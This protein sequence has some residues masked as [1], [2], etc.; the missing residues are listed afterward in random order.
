MAALK[1]LIRKE[2]IQ[3]WRNSF[4]PKLVFS[5]PVLVMLIVPLVANMEVKGV[6][7]AYVDNDASM[8][9]QRMLSH[10]S[11]SPHFK[12][13]TVTHDYAEAFRL[14]EDCK[15]DVILTIPDGFEP[16]MTSGNVKKIKID[17]NAV[18]ATKGMQGSQ[19]VVQ[20]IAMTLQEVMGEQGVTVSGSD[21][22][23]SIRYYYNETLDYRYYM[24]PAFMVILVLVICCFIPALNLVV[25][26]EKGT[27]EQI[28]VTPVR[29]IEFILS[30]LIPYWVIGIIVV[31]EAIVTVGLVYGL[32]PEGNIGALFLASLL[33]SLVLSGFAVAVANRSD[34]MQQC[35]FVMFF[36]VMVFMLMG[37]LL[38]PIS[39]MPEWA[40]EITTV[41]PTRYFI[42]IMRAVYLKGTTM[43]ELG[44]DYLALSGLAVAFCAVAALTYRKQL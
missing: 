39:S 18:N 9:S 13:S 4:L 22:C 12:I 3:F 25:E 41:I 28:N 15:T 26:K 36:F 33:F 8:T 5:F 14:L 1:F 10:L 24:I 29:K 31:A 17:A 30:K 20:T 11:A 40:Q 38:T 2:L 7:L 44:V 43:T 19:Y 23:T 42:N 6:K 21:E 16:S 34:T 27:I 35:I 37:G 32:W